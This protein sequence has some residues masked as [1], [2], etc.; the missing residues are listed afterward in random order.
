MQQSWPGGQHGGEQPC[1]PQMHGHWV[2]M[3]LGVTVQLHVFPTQ[4]QK[5]HELFAPTQQP[6][7]HDLPALL[8]QQ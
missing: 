2:P 4:L 8:W 5:W 1:A 3:S 6:W 7:L